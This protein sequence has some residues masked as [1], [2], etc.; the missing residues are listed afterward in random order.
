MPAIASRHVRHP[1]RPMQCRAGLIEAGGSAKKKSN[2][3]I[4]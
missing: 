1:L 3:K 4:V 2:E